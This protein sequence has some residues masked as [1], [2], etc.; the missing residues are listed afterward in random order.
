MDACHGRRCI[1]VIGLHVDDLICSGTPEVLRQLDT[2]LHKDFTVGSCERASDRRDGVNGFL[3]RGLRMYKKDRTHLQID[4]YEY[5]QREISPCRYEFGTHRTRATQKDKDTV[6]DQKGQDWYRA[7]IGKFIWLTCQVRAD[8]STPVS[9][10]AS[11]LGKATISDAINVN[12]LIDQV[13]SRKICLRFERITNKTRKRSLK[14]CCDAAFKNKNESSCKSRGGMMLL[15]AT[16][17]Q[18]TDVTALLGWSSKKIQRVCKSPTGAEVLTVSASV[19]EVDFAFHLAVAFYTDDLEFCSEIF[20]DSFSL[21]STQ[22]KYTKEINP[23]LQV[24]VAIIRQ[25]VRN[26]EVRLTHIPGEL[27]PS[28]GLTKS[29]YQAQNT[30]LKYFD[31]FR[32]GKGGV[33]YENVEA[34]L[35]KIYNDVS[36]PNKDY[37]TLERALRAY[38]KDLEL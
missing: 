30:L 18:I 36:V 4:M 8:L 23:N 2:L 3:Y 10:A 13:E 28:D 11:S 26:G 27:N 9:Q 16:D 35:A 38:V 17:T 14:F 20:T 7:I 1:G 19:D 5:E 29:E 6:L 12:N 24:D 15:L 33:S 32:I 34:L 25:K 21:T 37:P 22:E 31:T